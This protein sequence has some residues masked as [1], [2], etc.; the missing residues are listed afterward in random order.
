MSELSANN[1]RVGVSVLIKN[2]DKYLIG[3]RKSKHAPGTWA[4][5][6]GPS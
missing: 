4:Q 6:G 1:V 5:P 3:K 2:N